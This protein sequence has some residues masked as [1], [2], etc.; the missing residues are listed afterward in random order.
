METLMKR[1]NAVEIRINTLRLEIIAMNDELNRR[2]NDGNYG[3]EDVYLQLKLKFLAKKFEL[4]KM[5][6][7]RRLLEL[8]AQ[9]ARTAA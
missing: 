7:E 1:L 5:K 2:R 6:S 8:Q 3:L 4:A 9:G